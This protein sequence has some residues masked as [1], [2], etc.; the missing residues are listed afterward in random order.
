MNYRANTNLR[1]SNTWAGT[2]HHFNEDVWWCIEL[3]RKKKN[4]KI[5]GYKEAV[6]F[7][8]ENEPERAF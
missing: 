1:R 4:L 8:F 2:E 3:N 5:P 7:S 6:F